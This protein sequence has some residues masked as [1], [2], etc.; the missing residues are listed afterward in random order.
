[1]QGSKNEADI[2]IIHILYLFVRRRREGCMHIS[3]DQRYCYCFYSIDSHIG[4]I[5]IYI[6]LDMN[7]QITN[8]FKHG[9]FQSEEIHVLR[10]CEEEKK[11]SLLV[12]FYSIN[13]H[14]GCSQIYIY[15]LDMKYQITN[16]FKHGQFQSEENHILRFCEEEEKTSLL[17]N[18]HIKRTAYIDIVSILQLHNGCTG[19]KIK[20]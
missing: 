15:I 3:K 1:M 14:I 11:I 13:S 7:Y 9:Q 12:K 8:N 17:V 18:V 10:F 4:C 16:I 20:F 19:T 5:E 6:S 2:V